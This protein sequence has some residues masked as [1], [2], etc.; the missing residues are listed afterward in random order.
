MTMTG[1][2]VCPL[3]PAHL[4]GVAAIKLSII[5]A[6][7]RTELSALPLVIYVIMCVASSVRPAS[8]FFLPVISRGHTGK[9]IV[10]VTFD[11]GPD[12]ATTERL[13]DLLSRHAIRAAFFIPGRRALQYPELVKKILARGH[14][15]GNHSHSHDP[16]L[17]LRRTA[18]MDR[19]IA[20]AQQTLATFGIVPLT[21][22]PPVGA[23]NPKLWRILIRLGLVCVTFSCRAGDF[24]NRRIKGLAGRILRHVK[25]DDIILLHDVMPRKGMDVDGWLAEIE[26]IITGLKDKGLSIASL[27]EVIGQPVMA[28]PG[29]DGVLN[30]VVSFYDKLAT[31]Y[32]QEQFDS[33]VSLAKQKEYDTV[34]SR[35]PALVSSTG[36][37]LEIGAGTGIFSIPIAKLCRELVAVD[38]SGGMLAVLKRKA[39]SSGVRNIQCIAGDISTMNIPGTFDMICGFSSLE[40]IPDLSKLLKTLSSHLNPGGVLY[41]T[42]AHRSFFRFFTQIGNAMRQGLWLHARSR[43]EVKRMLDGAGME[44]MRIETHLLKVFP[45]GGMLLEVE[46]VRKNVLPPNKSR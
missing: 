16:F 39:S 29:S 42:T 26:Q 44:P 4:T 30:P 19:E 22:R 15:I 43:R 37:V 1:A 20:S 27:A 31:G 12:P 21:F 32:D 45:G 46:A 33:G 40:Y 23:T 5:F 25:P 36:R 14:D 17:M 6:F 13:L 3:S 2:T 7:F 41:F 38:I 11:D 18:F 8:R 28:L 24:G 35:L 10:A 9:K 34:L